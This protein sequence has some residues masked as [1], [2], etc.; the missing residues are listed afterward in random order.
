M[1][2]GSVPQL[3]PAFSSSPSSILNVLC[4][5]FLSL[6]IEISNVN[7]RSVCECLHSR[8]C[9]TVKEMPCSAICCCPAGPAVWN[10]WGMKGISFGAMIPGKKL[11]S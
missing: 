4:L 5:I 2:R 6:H 8:R 10:P 7:A 3:H 11:Y 1:E 9:S